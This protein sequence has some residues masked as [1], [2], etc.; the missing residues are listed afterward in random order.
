MPDCIVSDA[1]CCEDS[2]LMILPQTGWLLLQVA[3]L[4][5]RIRPQALVV[6]GLLSGVVQTFRRLRDER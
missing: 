2:S 4:M 6:P 1:S 3:V 5:H